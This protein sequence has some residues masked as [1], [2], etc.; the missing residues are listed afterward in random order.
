MRTAASAPR[1]QQRQPEATGRLIQSLHA[2]R[3]TIVYCVF[4]RSGILEPH[5]CRK[6]LGL[7]PLWR[8]PPW[9]VLNSLQRC[10]PPSCF[11]RKSQQEGRALSA[12][13]VLKYTQPWLFLASSE[14]A[15]K[16][17]QC[18]GPTCK[19]FD[20]VDWGSCRR[21]HA[22]DAPKVSLR[23]SQVLNIR[24]SLLLFSRSV[25]SDS[26]T[27]WTAAHKASLSFTVSQSLLKLMSI[28][29]MM[30]SNH[31]ILCGSLLLPS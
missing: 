3:R 5:P 10:R 24:L 6:A 9:G 12:A 19:D 26:A 30:P 17:Y 4:L 23:C 13:I 28:E 25:V 16:T 2:T 1:S 7:N 18:L 8:S 20:S 27:P 11:Q 31:L 14:G 15:F 29:L 21:Q 22:L